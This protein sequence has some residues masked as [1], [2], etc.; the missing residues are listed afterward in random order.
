MFVVAA[1]VA[2]SSGP[3]DATTS[4]TSVRPIVTG[5]LP[6]W[7]ATAATNTVTGNAD[8]FREASPFIWSVT[9]PT[10]V[11]LQLP[12]SSVQ[13]M[14]SALHARGIKVIPTF[15]TTMNADSFASLLRSRSERLQQVNAL[16]SAASRYGADGV[17]LDYENINF[18]SSAAR[19]TVKNTY[20]VLVRALQRELSAR[21]MTTV[22]TVPART[23]DTDPNWAVY[24]YANLGAAADL[25]RIMTY[26][27]HWGGGPPGAM[28]PRGW[29]N[30]VLAYAV[31]RVPSSKISFGMPSYGR[32][33]FDGTVSGSCPSAAHVTTSGTSAYFTA[34]AASRAIAMQ[35]DRAGSSRTFTYRKRYS[36]GSTTC[37]AKRVV[38]FDD[39]GS[40]RAKLPLVARYHLRG[41]AIWALGNETPGMWST[42]QSYAA[43]VAK[44]SVQLSTQAPDS[45]TYGSTGTIGG[46][47]RQSGAAVAGLGVQLQQRQSDGTWTVVA[48]DVSTATGQVSFPVTPQETSQYRL[49]SPATW[50]YRLSRST[51]L[52]LP[53]AYRVYLGATTQ[54]VTA[55]ARTYQ[56]AGHVNPGTGGTTVLLQFSRN[57]NWVT[58]SSSTTSAGGRY[59]FAVTVKHSG[60][61]F[62]RVLA[63]PGGSLTRG[64]SAV[65]K[66]TFN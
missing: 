12:S 65:V 9:S 16:V 44:K 62:V 26:D 41:I 23:S 17:D 29:V 10:S 8:L 63:G 14:V 33:W 47:V 55:S 30:R 36:T 54:R 34:F 35:W 11:N 39:A 42:L 5:W 25:F 7:N 66:A 48:R 57:G 28:A 22:V 24:D 49:V 45:L 43:S 53:V 3:S 31:T 27:Y 1:A 60:T 20:P 46:T 51:D 61:R 37:V 50:R 56:F 4:A 21:G 52:A 40:L 64:T 18:G 13:N 59:T 19:A 15:T 58:R 2:F 32:D 6:Y 38:W